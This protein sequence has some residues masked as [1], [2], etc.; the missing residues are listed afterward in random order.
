MPAAALSNAQA[1]CV[2]E[3]T[4]AEPY[5]SLAAFSLAYAMNSGSVLAGKSLPAISTRGCSATSPTGAKSE[6]GI[7]GQLLIERR[8]VG[9]R[10]NG[11][12]QHRITVR[13]GVRDAIDP[14]DTRGSADVFHNHLLTQYFAQSRCDDPR[15]HVEG[16]ARGKWNHKEIGRVGYACANARPGTADSTR[17]PTARCKNC[18]RSQSFTAFLQV[19]SPQ[20][21]LPHQLDQ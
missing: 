3:P 15:D 20:V 18:L 17:V 19:S 8:I 11:A 14:H 10:P 16:A 4:P 21:T 1:R 13:Y 5:C 9:M 12:E 2:V 6:D 7:V